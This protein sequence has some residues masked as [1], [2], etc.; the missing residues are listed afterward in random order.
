MEKKNQSIAVIGLSC[1]FPK[2]NTPKELWRL[3]FEGKSVIDK[4][5]ADRWDIDEYY[6]PDPNTPG[7]T[8]QKV[9]GFLE[10]IHHFD[11][12]FFNI[13]PKEAIEMNPSQKVMMELAWEL[14]ESSSL[15]PAQFMGT[16]TG[17]FVGN[18]WADFEHLRKMRKA[19]INNF[20]G[21]GQSSNV[22]ANRISYHFGLTGP[23]LVIDT[24]CSASL[25][26]LM[27]AVQSLRDGSSDMC[28]AGGVNHMLDPE[29]YVYLAKFGGLSSKGKCSAFDAD[30]DGFVRGEG[31]GALLL[32][33]LEDAERD[34][35][36]IYAVIR[37]GAITNNGYNVN[38]PAT[39]KKGQIEVM[40]QAYRDAGV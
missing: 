6:D 18:I 7:K 13:S 10:N 14:Y 29:E 28:I 19:E 24:G 33:R 12:Y 34:G 35:D 15:N 5:P 32:K 3:L 38:M 2:A 39:S 17:V 11:P 9:G 1:R 27:L 21:I 25:V 40:D 26:A 36:K 4:V 23:S 20:S 16:K 31:A 8:N 22:I 37:G 30:A